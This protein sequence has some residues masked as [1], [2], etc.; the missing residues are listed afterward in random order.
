MGK[1]YPIKFVEGRPDSLND[2]HLLPVN[3]ANFLII[4]DYMLECSESSEVQ[5]L[6]TQYVHYRNLSAIYIVQ[7]LFAQGKLC[8]TISLNTNYLILFKKPCD[9]NQ[10]MLLGRQ[11][12]PSNVKHFMECYQDATSLP[13][14]YLMIDYKA[15]TPDQY[16]LRI[17]LFSER[18]V[19]YLQKKKT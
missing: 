7:N 14:G 8:R 1:L 19:V 10:V 4:D 11:M 13:Y 6:F 15:K 18:Q 12:Y 5:K 3:K 16:R 2:D 17:G 9:A